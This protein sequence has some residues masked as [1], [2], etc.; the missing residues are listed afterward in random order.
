M[1]CVRQTVV[2][3]VDLSASQFHAHRFLED[4]ALALVCFVCLARAFRTKEA[5]ARWSQLWCSKRIAVRKRMMCTEDQFISEDKGVGI[6]FR[7][8]LEF[9]LL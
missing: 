7:R 4:V 5:I 2:Q 9:E 3:S 8:Q 1:L 6:A